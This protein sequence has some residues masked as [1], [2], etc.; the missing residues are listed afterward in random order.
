[1]MKDKHLA[2]SRQINQHKAEDLLNLDD[3]I[4]YTAINHLVTQQETHSQDTFKDNALLAHMAG[5]GLD[6]SPGDIRQ[7]LATHRSP[8]K[9]K[10]R[11]VN[12][13]SVPSTFQ[14]GDTTYYLNKRE[15]IA[16][17][18]HHYTAHMACIPYHVSQHDVSVLEQALIDRGANGGF[19]GDDMLVLE[20]S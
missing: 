5:I 15:T 6:T 8:G 13:T 3:L 20:G 16:F 1:M 9:N 2:T 10:T 14:I 7:V 17:Q 18:E 11:K 12:D 19:C 4:V